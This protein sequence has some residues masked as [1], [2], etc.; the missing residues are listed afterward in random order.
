MFLSEEKPRT[1]AQQKTDNPDWFRPVFPDK[2][3]H[4]IALTFSGGGFRAASFSLGVLSLF[5]AVK[6]TEG[7]L[8][9]RVTYIAS[10]SGGTITNACYALHCTN[11][12]YD[13]AA[14]YK[15]M[16]GFLNGTG[17]LQQA[18]EL[19]NDDK[20]WKDQ[21]KH[22]NLI[23][24]FARVYNKVIYNDATMGSLAPGSNSSS[25]I[26]EVCFNATEFYAGL[27]FRQQVK[28]QTDLLPDEFFFYGNFKVHE[29]GSWQLKF[30]L[31]DVLA[32]SSCFPGGFEPIIFPHDFVSQAELRDAKA[33][34]EMKPIT[35]S[36][37]EK[38]FREKKELGLMDGGITDNIALESVMLADQRRINKETS[39][40]RFGL[41]FPCDV[42][43]GNIEFYDLARPDKHSWWS[44]LTLRTI[45][46]ALIV[47]SVLGLIG[48]VACLVCKCAVATVVLGMLTSVAGLAFGLLQFVLTQ[49][50]T[51]GSKSNLNIPFPPTI[52]NTLKDY[53]LRSPFYVLSNLLKSRFDSM[54]ILNTDEFLRRIR[55]IQYNTM[56]EAPRWKNRRK[57]NHIYDLSKGNE[58]ERAKDEKAFPYLKPSAAIV[59]SADNAFAMGTTLWF[60]KEDDKA[61]RPKDLIACGQFTACRNLLLYIERLQQDPA[62]AMLEPSAK[63][64]VVDIK[65]QLKALWQQFQDDPRFMVNSA[66]L[67]ATPTKF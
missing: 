27:P 1:D 49:I 37:K 23:N 61:K 8:L 62:F 35:N 52:V 9:K 33:A 54:V 6:T 10:A 7:S 13:F 3:L 12:K 58:A 63:A 17:L 29:I 45:R 11:T 15:Q 50:N 18:M 57:T 24:A 44:N 60:T 53:L 66:E 20:Q 22:R 59:S 65:R 32:A 51:E 43:S 25:H 4:N 30:K 39:F 14:L 56:Y 41:I 28:M 64:D 34:L 36:D 46:L 31:A 21:S 48:T 40:E 16:R 2:P 38:A 26:E 19:L 67:L 47:V 5:D 55:Q 42:G